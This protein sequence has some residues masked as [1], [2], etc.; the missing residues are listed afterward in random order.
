MITHVDLHAGPRHRTS[1]RSTP[2]GCFRKPMSLW[3]RTEARYARRIA[4]VYPQAEPLAGAESREQGINGFYK[5][6]DNRKA[7]CHVRKVEPLSRA[8]RRASPAGSPGLRADQSDGRAERR[9]DRI[10]RRRTAA[11]GQSAGRL[12][13]A[14]KSSPRRRSSTC[15]STNC[16]RKAFSRSAARPARAR[17]QPGEPSAPG[18]WWWEEDD[19]KE[20]GLHVGED[21]VLRRGRGADEQG[22]AH[23]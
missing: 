23:A 17:L 15:R 5:S 13:R 10:R 21:G 4:A 19:K 20:C 3:E 11:Q 12:Q 18:R 1:R 2:D 8:A 9:A 22:D 6:V 7:C 16:T 14:S